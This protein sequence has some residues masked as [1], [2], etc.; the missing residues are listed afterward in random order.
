MGGIGLK[1]KIM[2]LQIATLFVGSIVGAGLSSGRELNQF[3]SVYG[4]ISL[5]GLLMCSGIYIVFGKIIVYISVQNKV[6]SY[7]EFV[8][9]VCPKY[10]ALF[11]N[12]ILT[13]S[14][15]SG[16]AI[17]MAGSASIIWQHFGLPKWVG[18]LLMIVCSIL[19]LLRNTEGLFEINTIVV[20]ILIIV[21]LSIF[22]VYYYYYP[23]HF[24]YE[25]LITIPNQKSNWLFSSIAYA[26]FNI[27]S[28][29]GVIV[30]ITNES[31]RPRLIIKGIM[32]GSVILTVLS[33]CIALLMLVNPFTPK[34]YEIPLLY[35]AHK[36]HRILE[37]GMLA[38]I[39]LEMFSTQVSNVYSL[40]KSMENKWGIHYKRAVFI[41]IGIAL[42]FSF[43][44]FSRLVEILYPL[45]G[46]LSL[47]FLGCC[48]CYIVKNKQVTNTMLRKR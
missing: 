14:L 6:K 13:L 24:T 4:L 40:S 34:M 18:F 48:F 12:I 21:I 5:L 9:I 28:I 26:S 36:T 27:I 1:Q 38:V 31:K 15:L 45:Y 3:F 41:I 20:P 29:V 32:L 7:D 2:V 37:A 44:G 19:F 47:I 11:I 17:I 33:I 46:A 8:D 22:S 23:W 25:Y 10:I 39:W 30:P 42:P 43:F 16:T 35:I